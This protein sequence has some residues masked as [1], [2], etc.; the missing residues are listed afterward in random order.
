MNEWLFHNE[1]AI[2][3]LDIHILVD[4]TSSIF[5]SIVNKFLTSFD[6][7]I[8]MMIIILVKEIVIKN[9]KKLKGEG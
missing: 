4:I 7:F 6:Y 3:I 9:K 8:F 5:L 2:F 1:A